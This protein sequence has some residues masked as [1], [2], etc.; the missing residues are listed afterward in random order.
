[1]NSYT[2]SNVAIDQDHILSIKILNPF[3]FSVLP[4]WSTT[5]LHRN[6]CNWLHKSF[7][8]KCFCDEES[9]SKYYWTHFKL[10]IRLNGVWFVKTYSFKIETDSGKWP[11]RDGLLVIY[12]TNFPLSEDLRILKS[13]GIKDPRILRISKS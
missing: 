3:L 12:T 13:W 7:E 2:S 9:N 11:S 5:T 6:I 4:G 8:S 1:M 10:H